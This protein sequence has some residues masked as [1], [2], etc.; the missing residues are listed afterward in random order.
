MY[1][2]SKYKCEKVCLKKK[3][4]L[5][6]RLSNIVGPKKFMRKS[7][8]KSFIYNKNPKIKYTE[9]SKFSLTD[10]DEI[11][12]FIKISLKKKSYGVHNLFREN[13]VS[14]KEVSKRLKKKTTFGNLYFESFGQLTYPTTKTKPTKLYNFKKKRSL[15]VFKKYLLN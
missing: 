10:F 11:V 4:S 7:D 9:T 13:M 6:L 2:L 5:V 8:L 14:L 1:A 12:E 3:N 15:E